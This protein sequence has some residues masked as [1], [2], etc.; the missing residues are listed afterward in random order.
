MASAA[1]VRLRP[2][3][4]IRRA[5]P[6][7]APALG[8]LAVRSKAAWGYAPAEM[9]VFEAELRIAPEAIVAGRAF[10]LEGWGR[11]A[12][13]YTLEPAERGGLELGHL[14]VEPALMGRGVGAHLLTHARAQAE[15]RGERRLLVLSD[16]HAER[17][18]RRHGAVRL[19]LVPSSIPGRLLPLLEIEL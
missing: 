17:F 11:V 10:V 19:R 12:G 6:H 5:W 2:T 7:E 1:F 9:A 4:R 15:R 8:A 13:F 18:Y 3:W 16:P 14:F